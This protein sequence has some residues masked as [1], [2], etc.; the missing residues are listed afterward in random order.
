[1]ADLEI[2]LRVSGF[3]E[4]CRSSEVRSEG[5]RSRRAFLVGCL[6]RL[7]ILAPALSSRRVRFGLLDVIV[8]CRGLWFSSFD[9]SRFTPALISSS[10]IT[11]R[12]EV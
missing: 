6:F 1:M 8:R 5:C 2:R 10:I 3:C 4:R 12:V 9:S 11:D 7:G